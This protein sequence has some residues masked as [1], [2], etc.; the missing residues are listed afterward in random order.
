MERLVEQARSGRLPN[1]L[2]EST[3][4]AQQRQSRERQRGIL[5]GFNFRSEFMGVEQIW[6]RVQ[7]AA[8]GQSPL[9][10]AL[11]QATLQGNQHFREL[12]GLTERQVEIL[13]RNPP[14]PATAP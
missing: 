14:M 2:P 1:L 9:D 4:A 8:A 10:Q 11:L 3:E 6:R 7:Q 5:Q 13:R 12:I